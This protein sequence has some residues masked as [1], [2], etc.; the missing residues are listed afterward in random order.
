MQTKEALLEKMPL[1]TLQYY[2]QNAKQ[3]A[4]SYERADLSNIYRTLKE[5]FIKPVRLLELGGGSGR[6]AAFLLGQGHD[7]FFSDASLLMIR[8]AISFHPELKFQ[9]LVCKAEAFLPFTEDCFDGVVAIA[10]LMHLTIPSIIQSMSE[11]H[12][13]IKPGGAIII[14]I[15]ATRDDLI[16]EAR[17]QKGRLMTTIDIPSLVR[18]DFRGRLTLLSE[19]RNSD[20]LDRGGIQWH[21]CCLI[22]DMM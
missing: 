18:N 7:L 5:L 17:D 3:I 9:A 2:E 10:V 16:T 20:G 14:S 12:R 15:P 13:V 6:D 1:K 19:I 21:T 4:V 8:E 22:K 11:M